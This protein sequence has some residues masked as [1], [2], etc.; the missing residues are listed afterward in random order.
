MKNK[1]NTVKI[2]KFFILGIV[3]LFGL[4]MIKLVY[5]ALTHNIDDINLRLFILC[6]FYI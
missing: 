4:I 6:N 3:F 2:N 5:I 1:N